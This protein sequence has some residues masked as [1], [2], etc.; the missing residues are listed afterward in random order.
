LDHFNT[1]VSER[2]HRY[3]QHLKQVMADAH[4]KPKEVDEVVLVGGTSRIIKLQVQT[5]KLFGDRALLIEDDEC[6]QA[7]AR[8]A[9]IYVAKEV[10]DCLEDKKRSLKQ[11]ACGQQ[12]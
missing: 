8:G 6:D 2:V 4:I 3:I 11:E 1:L 12:A 10:Q 5:K 7:V 9:M